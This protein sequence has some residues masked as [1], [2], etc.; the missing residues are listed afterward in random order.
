MSGFIGRAQI[1]RTTQDQR[2]AE[3]GAAPAWRGGEGGGPEAGAV[4]PVAVRCIALFGVSFG[5]TAF[6]VWR[7]LKPFGLD[8]RVEFIG[9]SGWFGGG[10][11]GRPSPCSLSVEA[12]RFGLVAGRF[13]TDVRVKSG[14]G[15]IGRQGRKDQVCCSSFGWFG[16]GGT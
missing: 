5:M 16:G 10:G 2:T 13:G 9:L 1:R 7:R 14:G 8:E 11:S 12:K 15:R 3:G 4:T 6:G